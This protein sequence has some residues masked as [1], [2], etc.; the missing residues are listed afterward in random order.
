MSRARDQA[1]TFKRIITGQFVVVAVLLGLLFNAQRGWHTAGLAQPL[2]LPPDLRSGAMIKKGEPGAHS[3]YAFAG[4]M[5]QQL[6]AWENGQ[7]DF[8]ANIFK[9]QAFLTPEFR[10]YLEAD[11]RKRAA[12]GELRDRERG[13]SDTDGYTEARVAPQG[14]G[15]WLVHL[16][17]QVNEWVEGEKVKNTRVSYPV[18]VRVFDMDPEKN[19]WGL[20]LDGFATTPARVAEESLEVTPGRS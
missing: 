5:L 19:P 14:N 16:T 12:R 2:H 1:T 15:L 3:V 6:Y 11:M 17:F 8:G 9:L 20:A 4:Y 10:A 18:R 7:T 13:V